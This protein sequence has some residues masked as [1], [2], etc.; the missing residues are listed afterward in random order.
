MAYGKSSL[1]ALSS[2]RLRLRLAVGTL[3]ASRV[4]ANFQRPDDE[5]QM[6]TPIG[7]R[8]RAPVPNAARSGPPARGGAPPDGESTKAKMPPRR[9]WAT[10]LLVVL[11]NFFLVRLLV[12]SGET[13]KVPYTLFREE[14]GRKNVEAIYS[15]GASITG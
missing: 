1:T 7:D 15:R 9:T 11:A 3:S 6:A 5:S 10:F 2:G 4:A 13:V 14:V 12:P 8:P